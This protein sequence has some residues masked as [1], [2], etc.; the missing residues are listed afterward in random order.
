M[1]TPDLADDLLIGAA[2]IARA[3][4]FLRK[5]GEPNVRRVYH[6]AEQPGFPVHRQPGLGL[7]ARKSTLRQHFDDLEN[8]E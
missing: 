8:G 2:D 6:L 7:V 4:G 5:N 1:E 3:L